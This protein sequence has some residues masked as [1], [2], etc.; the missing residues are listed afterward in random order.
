MS[1]RYCA[2]ETNDTF[3]ARAHQQQATLLVRVANTGG[4]TLTKRISGIFCVLC[5]VWKKWQ[6]ELLQNLTW[7]LI[8]KC[9]KSQSKGII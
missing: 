2:V 6:T 3:Y 1:D 4:L 7:I 8:E 9:Q 5:P